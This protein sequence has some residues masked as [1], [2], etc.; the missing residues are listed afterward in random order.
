[1]GMVFASTI[2]LF[3]VL[4]GNIKKH[5]RN[6]LGSSVSPAHRD[7]SND[8]TFGQIKS[9]VPVPLSTV[10]LRECIAV[11]H[12]SLESEYEC[13]LFWWYTAGMQRMDRGVVGRTKFLKFLKTPEF[14]P[15]F[16]TGKQSL[17]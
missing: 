14:Q 4:M 16:P 3:E 1:M 11:I 10:S 13:H 2:K 17:N 5:F 6:F 8:A 15:F 7:L 9:R 12:T